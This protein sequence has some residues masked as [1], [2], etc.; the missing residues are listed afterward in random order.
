MAGRLLL[1]SPQEKSLVPHRRRPSLV[2]HPF[3][4][5]SGGTGFVFSLLSVCAPTPV[6]K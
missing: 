5:G 2:P 6:R 1:Y 4:V 3:E